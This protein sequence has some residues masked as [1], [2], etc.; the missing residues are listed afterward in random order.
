MPVIILVAD[1]ARPDTLAGAIESGRLPALGRMA[2]EGSSHVVTTVFPAV[3]GPAYTPFVL[4]RFPGNVG[5][6]GLRWFDRARD[7]TRMFGHAISYVGSGVRFIDK[8]ID[9]DAAS[10]FQLAPPGL[11]ALCVVRRGLPSKDQLGTSALYALRGAM[12]H[13]RGD[14]SGWLDIDRRIGREFVSRLHAKRPRSPFA[15]AAFMGV[16]KMSHA[17]GHDSAASLE[18]LEIVDAVAAALRS[19][20]EESGIWDST[21]IWVTSDHGHSPVLH[22]DEL[23]SFFRARGHSTVSHPL[24]LGLRGDVAI[25]VSGNAMAHIYFE[26]SRRRRPFWPDLVSRWDAD[27]DELLRSP[28]VDLA[29]IPH[30]ASR[31]EVRSASRGSAFVE[32]QGDRYNYLPESGDPLHLGELKGLNSDDAHMAT[33][34]TAY[35]DSVV[36]IAHLAAC[37]RSGDVLLSASPEWDFRRDFEP[38]PHVS[39]HGALVR[40]HMLVPLITNHPVGRP[41]LRTVDLMPSACDALGLPMPENCDGRS[42]M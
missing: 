34:N 39:T 33:F 40:E 27:V 7:I 9:A 24:T 22:H 8:D 38:V 32:F 16:D 35:P 18:A 12:A 5:L 19:H 11:S 17:Y 3:T 30:S 13:F 41:P 42:F 2:R 20:A 28:S 4:G 1:G 23:V 37:E 6:P 14:V 10:M 25:M 36:Q 26:L 31:C 29:L 21:H 15:L